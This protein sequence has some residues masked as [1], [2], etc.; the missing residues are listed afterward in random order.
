MSS[1]IGLLARC[2][3]RA[4]TLCL[5]AAPAMAIAQGF[6]A[7][8]S[9]PRVLMQ[10]QPGQ[11]LRQVIEIQHAGNQPGRY[12]FYTVDWGLNANGTVE[13]SQELV[14]QSCRPW[15]AIERR[16][17][18]LGPGDRYRYRFEVQTPAGTPARECRFAIMMEGL[19]PA[20]VGG[21]LNMPVSGRIGV[22]VY[23]NVGG[24]KPQ[25]ELVDHRTDTEGERKTPVL[26]VRNQGQAHGRL[27]GFLDGRDADGRRF[28]LAPQDLPVLPGEA[29]RIALI[30]LDQERPDAV[31]PRYPLRVE[32]RLEWGDQR[33]PI[34]LTFTP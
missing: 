5:T 4:L 7:Y 19:D 9:P 15:V 12:R 1:D 13:F 33:L 31:K 32:G 18:T 30:V 25:L 22:V 21:G 14:P 10:S 26:I 29:R 16:E 28:E 27:E 6:S 17:L 24:A 8:V 2:L 20:A 34:D 23:V 3:A 11:T